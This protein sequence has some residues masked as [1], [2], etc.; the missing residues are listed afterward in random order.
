MIKSHWAVVL[1]RD[2]GK[3]ALYLPSLKV[4]AGEY[5]RQHG[6]GH[7]QYAIGSDL[8]APLRECFRSP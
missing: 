1:N 7:E 6:L 2:T 3:L 8:V 4:L 5:R